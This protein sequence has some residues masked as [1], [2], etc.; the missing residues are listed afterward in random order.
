MV[1]DYILVDVYVAL[2]VCASA[3]RNL[4]RVLFCGFRNLWERM[5]GMASDWQSGVRK[6]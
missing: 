6:L 1:V 4:T 3:V 5:G 2:A